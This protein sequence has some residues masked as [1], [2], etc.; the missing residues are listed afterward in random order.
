MH[1]P[2]SIGGWVQPIRL[3]FIAL[4]SFRVRPVFI[5]RPLTFVYTTCARHVVAAPM[6]AAILASSNMPAASLQEA[7]L[8]HPDRQGLDNA[9]LERR[10]SLMQ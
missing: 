2:E 6:A 4:D 7:L 5:E 3:G 8:P 9:T 10:F 1:S